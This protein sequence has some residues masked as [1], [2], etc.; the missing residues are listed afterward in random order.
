MTR[1]KNAYIAGAEAALER[2]GVKEA[3]LGAALPMLGS[4]AA[5]AVARAGLQRFAPKMLGALGNGFKGQMFDAAASM[6]GGALGQKMTGP[7]RQQ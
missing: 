5:P 4:I 6:A 2:L 3:F 7:P 1:L